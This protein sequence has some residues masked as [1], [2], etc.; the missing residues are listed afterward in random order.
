MEFNDGEKV[1]VPYDQ[2][3]SLPMLYYF[4]DVDNSAT[5]L[6]TSLYSCV[7]EEINQNLS[8]A[9]KEMLR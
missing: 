1:K 8:R 5:K 7:T 2:L 3:T 4:D 6:E 9:C